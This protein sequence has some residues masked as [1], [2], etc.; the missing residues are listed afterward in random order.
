MAFFLERPLQQF[1]HA[2]FVF[3]DQNLHAPIVA[4]PGSVGL[5]SWLRVGS[6]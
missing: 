6:L 2:A 1:G 4:L 3:D 5:V